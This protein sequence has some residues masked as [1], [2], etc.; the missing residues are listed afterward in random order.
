MAGP[1]PAV[2]SADGR[3]LL[4]RL[5]SVDG[6]R[7]LSFGRDGSEPAAEVADAVVAGLVAECALVVV[8]A[9][10]AGGTVAVAALAVADQVLI[11]AGTG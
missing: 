7:V 3:A 9:S 2:G 4:V 10:A 5:P 8:D 6:V 11:V 1:L